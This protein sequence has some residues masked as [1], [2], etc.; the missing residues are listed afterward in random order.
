M[1][2][3]EIWSMVHAERDALASDMAGLDSEQWAAPTV[4]AGWDVRDVPAHLVDT[5]KTSRRRFVVGMVRSR[6]DFDALNEWG[7]RRE[8]QSDPARTLAEFRAVSRSTD[9]PPAPLATRLVEAIVHGEDIRRAVGTS[10][11]YPVDAVQTALDYQ[12]RT[13][14]TWGGGKERAAGR[15]LVATDAP[16]AVGSGDEV[17]ATALDLL[18]L[19]SGRAIEPASRTG[20]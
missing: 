18:L 9:T 5:A 8:R 1:R 19:L 20:L 7:I 14:V 10:G 6:F 2:P 16:F 13:P 11:R 3:S 4:S 12:L 15:R 17:R